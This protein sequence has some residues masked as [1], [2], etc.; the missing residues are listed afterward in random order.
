MAPHP[1]LPP[2]GFL[3][4][5]ITHSHGAAQDHHRSSHLRSSAGA[6]S[7]EHQEFL[8]AATSPSSTWPPQPAPRLS[9]R[10]WHAQEEGHA[11]PTHHQ[12]CM[13][14]PQVHQQ[15]PKEAVL[16]HSA[17]LFAEQLS[18]RCSVSQ[19]SNTFQVLDIS[20][21]ESSQLP[22]VS[23]VSSLMSTQTLCSFPLIVY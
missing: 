7:K 15:H 9:H 14:A 10:R 13:R 5:L 12:C 3:P 11:T 22:S 23:F 8:V 19:I 4:Y 18:H 6:G 20:L 21:D 2:R 16:S 1:F 17:V